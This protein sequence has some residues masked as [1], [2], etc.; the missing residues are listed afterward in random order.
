MAQEEKAPSQADNTS[1]IQVSPE[2]VNLVTAIVSR[3]GSAKSQEPEVE[4][5]AMSVEEFSANGH[6]G[7]LICG[8]IYAPD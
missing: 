2:F 6:R 3:H 7:D 5:H 4:G 8:L 1:L